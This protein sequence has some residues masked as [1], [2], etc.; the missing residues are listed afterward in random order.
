MKTA[1][2]NYQFCVVR[3]Q[4]QHDDNYNFNYLLVHG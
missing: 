2:D 1:K 4:N 3:F